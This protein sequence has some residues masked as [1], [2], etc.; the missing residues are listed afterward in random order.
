VKE[1]IFEGIKV[2]RIN[3]SLENILEKYLDCDVTLIPC[4]GGDKIIAAREQWNDGVNMLTISPGV[5]VSYDR[6]NVTN[7]VLKRYGVTVLE[8]RGS[9]LSRGRGGPRC[10]SLPLIRNNK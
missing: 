7:A 9:E 5:V 6:N 8:I 3:D 2:K 4:G 10:M 1:D